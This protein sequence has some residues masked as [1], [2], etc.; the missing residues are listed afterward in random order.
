MLTRL[1]ALTGLTL[2]ALL[3]SACAGGGESATD[4][5]EVTTLRLGHALD[6]DHPQHV[7]A[8]HLAE[9]VARLSDGSMK[10]ELFPDASLGD[11]VQL[12]ESVSSG[13]L[14]MSIAGNSTTFAPRSA[15][16]LL[17]YLFTDADSAYRVANGELAE[18]IYTEYGEHGISVL[19]VYNNGFRQITNSKRPVESPQDLSGLKIRVPDARVWIATLEALGANPMPMA[20]TEV[21]SSLQQGVLDGQENPVLLTFSSRMFEVQKHIAITNHMWQGA[22]VLVNE[23]VLAGL[24]AEDADTLREAVAAS[25]EHNWKV[26]AERDTELLGE[27]ETKGMQ[28][29]TPDLEPFRVAAQPVYGQVADLVGGEDFIEKVREAAAGH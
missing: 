26:V 14:D 18:E 20:F 11:D 13:A 21:Y 15:V 22:P 9:E 19:G 17:P 12:Q 6:R 4:S 1:R 25:V 23:K 29:T 8:E 5:G 27:L 3:L 16:L 2:T 7:A 10:V 24:S 28:V